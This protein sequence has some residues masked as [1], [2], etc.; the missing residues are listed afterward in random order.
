MKYLKKKKK[1]HHY[2]IA[3]SNSCIN[4]P[5]EEEILHPMNLHLIQMHL[6]TIHLYLNL[7]CGLSK[8][9]NIAAVQ[10]QTSKNTNDIDENIINN[11]EDVVIII[12]KNTKGINNNNNNIN[13]KPAVPTSLP[14]PIPKGK[15]DNNNNKNNLKQKGK[16]E[17]FHTYNP[18]LAVG[19][20]TVI[21]LIEVFIRDENKF[22]LTKDTALIRMRGIGQII[23]TANDEILICS[24]WPLNISETIWAI[25]KR[26]ETISSLSPEFFHQYNKNNRIEIEFF[27]KYQ[28]GEIRQSTNV[29]KLISKIDTYIIQSNKISDDELESFGGVA[30]DYCVNLNRCGSL[31]FDKVYKILL[32]NGGREI[33]FKLLEPYILNEKYK[34]YHLNLCKNLLIFVYQKINFQNYNK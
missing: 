4:G 19:S 25:K 10:Q 7:L 8:Y 3:V 9:D 27:N 11:D 18:V 24:G 17:H 21:Q 16:K 13:N 1:Q 33:F 12:Y 28:L 30:M 32:N 14:P 31:L 23:L 5:F 34:H 15:D 2:H 20:G 26:N 6:H 22:N 29:N